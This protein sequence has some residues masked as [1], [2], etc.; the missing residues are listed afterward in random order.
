MPTYD[1]FLSYS[2]AEDRGVARRLH[3]GVEKF[4]KP[5]YRARG[6]RLFLDENSLSANPGL[7]SSIES[8]LADSSWFVLVTSPRAAGSK[9]VD[10]EIRWWLQN[11]SPDRLLI[12]L[13]DGE[14]IWDQ[15]AGDFDAKGSTALPPALLGV[16]AE[17]PLWVTVPEGASEELELREAIVDVATAMSAGTRP[18]RSWNSEISPLVEIRPIR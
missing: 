1:A 2:H 5:W 14:L 17:E 4:A 7:W 8:A 6:L 18:G 9:W 15:E 11:R 10:R 13:A 16:L 3:T 12:V